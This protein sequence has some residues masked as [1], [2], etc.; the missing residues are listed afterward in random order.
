MDLL[1][2]FL[3][4]ATI[5]LIRKLSND[6]VN[7][8]CHCE[9]QNFRMGK[10]HFEFACLLFFGWSFQHWILRSPILKCELMASKWIFHGI[11]NDPNHN[12]FPWK[13]TP[14]KRHT[15]SHVCDT[16]ESQILITSREG[17]SERGRERDKSYILA[18]LSLKGDGGVYL[19]HRHDI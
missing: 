4:C 5:W 17:E 16:D 11:Q 12:E 2:I 18:Q 9:T 14:L 10:I 3:V 7:D 13:N 19:G 6:N 15:M 8:R 1:S